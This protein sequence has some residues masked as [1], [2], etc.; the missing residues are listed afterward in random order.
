MAVAVATEGVAAST[1]SLKEIL[2]NPWSYFPSL[3]GG[4]LVGLGQ[5]GPNRFLAAFGRSWSSGTPSQTAPP[6]FTETVT[7]GPRLFEIDTASREVSEITSSLLLS[8]NAS[9]RAAVMGGTGMHLIVSTDTG[10]HAQFVQNWGHETI[11]TLDHK[12]LSPSV[13]SNGEK[14]A[15]EWDRGAAYD[16]QGFVAVGADSQNRLYASLV[17]TTFSGARGYDPSRR[18]YLSDKGWTRDAAEQTPLTRTGGQILTSTVPVGLTYRR[19]G[20]LMLLP[21]QVGPNWGWELLRSPSLTSPFSHVE[22][23]PGASAGPAPARFLPGIALQADPTGPPGTAWCHSPE[24]S[25]SFVPQLA[26]LSV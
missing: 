19:Q 24:L 21:K 4:D 13:W 17:I 26:Q 1:D 20:W 9:L 14:S 18:S 11:R 25:G 6:T 7:T 10:T 16:R 22:D 12:P 23:I 8:P 3:V 2:S 15:V 5:V